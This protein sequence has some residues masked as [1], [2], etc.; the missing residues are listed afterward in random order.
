MLVHNGGL[1]NYSD[2]DGDLVGDSDN[3]GGSSVGISFRCASNGDHL[4][5]TLVFLGESVSAAFRQVIGSRGE[6]DVNVDL[7]LSRTTS[8]S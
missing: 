4:L 1:V 3:V 7:T 5:S 8:L 2:G 6:A